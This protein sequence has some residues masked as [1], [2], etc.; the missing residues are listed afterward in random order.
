M[1]ERVRWTGKI[2]DANGRVGKLEM[3]AAEG[4][5]GDFSVELQERDGRPVVLKGRVTLT[6]DGSTIRLRSSMGTEQRARS[7]EWDVNLAR[8]EAGRYARE[9]MLGTY[10]TAGGGPELPLTQGVV[11]LWHF[12]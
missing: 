5:E 10:G 1:A 3:N 4:A 2:L 12:S 9:A 7:L 6:S 8:A 11:I